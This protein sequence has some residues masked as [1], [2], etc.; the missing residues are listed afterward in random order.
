MSE[1]VSGVKNILA[2]KSSRILRNLTQLPKKWH[3][4]LN[5]IK[6]LNVLLIVAINLLLIPNQL[7]LNK[8]L[9]LARFSFCLMNLGGTLLWI[10]PEIPKRFCIS[11]ERAW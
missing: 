11:F 9:R 6:D 10:A 1:F 8:R 7:I 5:F 4:A 2:S 3:I